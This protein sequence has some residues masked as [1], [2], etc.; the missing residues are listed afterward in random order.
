MIAWLS[1]AGALAVYLYHL[2]QQLITPNPSVYAFAAKPLSDDEL[3]KLAYPT[4]DEIIDSIKAAGTATGRA[5]VVVGGSGLVGRFIVKSLLA[6]GETLVRIIDVA[7]PPVSNDQVA[8]GDLSRA[9]FIK[10]DVTNYESIKDAIS[11]PFRDTGRT[12]EVVFHVVAVIR[13]WERLAY[14]K[15]L[16]HAVNVGGTQNVL[17]VSQEL[18]TVRSFVFTSSMGAYLPPAMY[19]RLGLY[20]RRV[21]FGEDPPA[22]MKLA[23]HHYPTTKREADVLVR[24]ADGVKGIR[25]G[26]IRPGMAITGPGDMFITNYHSNPGPNV[27]WSGRFF[28]NIVGPWDLARAHLQL[29]DALLTR[30]DEV[31]GKG[32]NIT[33]QSTAHSFDEM[34]HVIQF[35]SRRDMGFKTLPALPLYF[36]SHQLEWFFLLRYYTLSALSK[37]NGKQATYLPQWAVSSKVAMFQPSMWDFGFAD[38]IV[39]DSRARKVLGYRNL[40]STEQTIKWTIETLEGGSS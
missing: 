10:A 16:S 40:W 39:D 32:Y 29:A 38:Y 11:R 15:H 28:Q 12:A 19:L 23:T 27:T 21:T 30:P 17:K 34:R 4:P 1:C 31:A 7:P 26:V 6:R 2:N 37:I 22:D 5:Y 25:T 18:G 35:Y 13:H 33:G 9:E 3:A 8:V 20:S 24:A 14:L 36:I